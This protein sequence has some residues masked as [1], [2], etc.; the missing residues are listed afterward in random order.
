MSGLRVR[1]KLSFV[2]DFGKDPL[3]KMGNL[4]DAYEGALR[5]LYPEG[6]TD[7]AGWTIEPEGLTSFTQL[8]RKR[9]EKKEPT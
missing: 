7:P 1:I 2:V 9:A 3:P 6:T 4:L 5:G 8:R